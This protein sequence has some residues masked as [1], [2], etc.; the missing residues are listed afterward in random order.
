[1]RLLLCA[2]TFAVFACNAW[3][4]VDPVGFYTDK[5]S[6]APSDK[7]RI[8]ANWKTSNGPVQF[9]YYLHRVG[10]DSMGQWT[11]DIMWRSC[12]SC[13]SGAMRSAGRPAARLA[14]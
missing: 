4:Q 11:T 3:A 7:V 10:R 13:G 5:P 8:H 2:T 9:K 1:M 12:H 14:A 6:Y